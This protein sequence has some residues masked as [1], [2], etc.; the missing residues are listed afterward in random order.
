MRLLVILLDVSNSSAKECARKLHTLNVQVHDSKRKNLSLFQSSYIQLQ[1]IM[2]SLTSRKYT[3][4]EVPSKKQKKKNPQEMEKR[5][6]R[7]KGGK[8]YVRQRERKREGKE[9]KKERVRK[10]RGKRMR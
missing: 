7:K 1:S 9:R 3:V 8:E 10:E 5:R 2:S 6:R 4:Q